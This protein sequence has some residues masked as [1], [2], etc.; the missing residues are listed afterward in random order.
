MQRGDVYRVRTCVVKRYAIRTET[1]LSGD[2]AVVDPA[3]TGEVGGLGAVEAVVEAGVVA[4]R[5]RDHELPGLLCYLTV[6]V[7]IHKPTLRNRSF[8]LP[9]FFRNTDS[10]NVSITSQ[11]HYKAKWKHV[12]MWKHHT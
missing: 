6:Y 12:H 2:L 10:L 1:Y 11:L 7:Y 3:Q 5:K 4:V 9:F 8:F